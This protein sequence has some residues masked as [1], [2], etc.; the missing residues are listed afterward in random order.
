MILIIAFK[1]CGLLFKHKLV[2]SGKIAILLSH[3]SIYHGIYMV[4]K[5][6]LALKLAFTVYCEILLLKCGAA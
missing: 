6:M 3:I 4:T 2:L 5:K 1:Y